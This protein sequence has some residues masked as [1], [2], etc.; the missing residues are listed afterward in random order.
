ME[1]RYL[2]LGDHL[3]DYHSAWAEQRRAHALVAAGELGPQVIFVEHAPVYTAGRRTLP[4]EYPSDGDR[5]SV[6]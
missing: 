3:V 4:E 6:V 1:F 2:G 5:K